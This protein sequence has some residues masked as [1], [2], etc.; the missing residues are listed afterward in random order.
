MIV[1]GEKQNLGV[2]VSYTSPS[3]EQEILTEMYCTWEVHKTDKR[4]QN[5]NVSPNSADQ[6]Q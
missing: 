1:K 6:S 2:W 5:D 3:S 4:Y